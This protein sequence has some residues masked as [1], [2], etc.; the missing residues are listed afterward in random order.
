MEMRRKILAPK[1]N[2]S[3]KDLEFTIMTLEK[4][5][6]Q[7]EEA[8]AEKFDEKNK[9]MI[10]I[11]MLPQVLRQRVKDLKGP[12]RFDSYEAVRAEA[13]IWLADN[14]PQKGKLA[15]ISE[16]P[17]Y[18]LPEVT[19]DNLGEFLSNPDNAE[20]PPDVL[21]AIVKNAHLKKAKGSCKGNGGGKGGGKDRGLRLCY[22]CDSPEHIGANCL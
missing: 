9:F 18:E 13:L 22:E 10:L 14:A 4:E 11:N 7:F 5:V 8:A 6:L 21:L 19:F 15:A 17:E 2:V 3:A 1:T 12:G 20:T 16:V